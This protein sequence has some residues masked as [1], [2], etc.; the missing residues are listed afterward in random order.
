V[1][2]QVCVIIMEEQTIQN[3][4]P[5]SIDSL[6]NKPKSKRP[7]MKKLFKESV[8][9]LT[10]SLTKR[11]YDNTSDVIFSFEHL[12]V[13]VKERSILK[14][15]SL[16]L[17]KSNQIIVIAGASGCGKTTLL[18]VINNY[19]LPAPYVLSGKLNY[20]HSNIKMIGHKPI[21]NPY[22]TVKETVQLFID[23]Y[24]YTHSVDYYLERFRLMGIKDKYI[25]NDENKSL[26][27]GQLVQL[28]ILLNTME[29]P[30]LLILDEPLSNLDIKTSIH[31]MKLLK[32]LDIPIIL[33]LHHPNNIIL[34]SVDQLIVME[35]G[36]IV[37][38]TSLLEITNRLEY[39]E[40]QILGAPQNED[41]IADETNL[42]KREELQIMDYKEYIAD[43]NTFQKCFNSVYSIATILIRKTKYVNSVC[44]IMALFPSL[45]FIFLQGTSYNDKLSGHINLT[46]DILF[47]VL[48]QSLISSLT[49]FEYSKIIPFIKYTSSLQI[50][51]YN[52]FNLLFFVL[53]FIFT[54][55]LYFIFMSLSSCTLSEDNIKIFPI[56][57]FIILVSRFVYYIF[58]GSVIYHIEDINM[59]NAVIN[60]YEMIQMLN[61]GLFGLKY[62]NL[63][64]ISIYYYLFNIILVKAQ[65]LY[66]YPL[67]PNGEYQYTVYGYSSDISYHYYAFL[68][69]FF[70]P[71]VIYMIPKKSQVFLT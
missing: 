12:S 34:E 68:G 31:I 6:D 28:S 56:F 58:A 63:K 66:D 13:F 10:R 51:N 4:E 49:A 14:N 3:K 15:V 1:K 8:K 5:D 37:L 57:L 65:E 20:H 25:G 54:A 71:S 30:D 22:L 42:I 53:T 39:Y 67:L 44:I 26:S 32:E 59:T 41:K 7:T 29:T 64:Y 43:V 61:C 9:S 24:R 23:S 33:T 19:D 46:F 35:E 69:F 16:T 11:V 60:V 18:N 38:N 27:T 45:Y 52:T 70:L 36:E 48:T 21:F 47:N 2:S 62:N 17:P 50:F 40:Q 55:S